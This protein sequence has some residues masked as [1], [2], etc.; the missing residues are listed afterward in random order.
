MRSKKIPVGLVLLVSLVFVGFGDQFLPPEIGKYSF[1]TRN[2]IDQMLV[3]AFPNRR[4][5]TDP[6][7]R[8][9]EAVENIRK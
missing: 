3:N 5:K 2:A 1:Q 7:R 8:T 9:N 6:Y 4:P